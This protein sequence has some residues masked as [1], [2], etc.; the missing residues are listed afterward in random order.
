MK[1]GNTRKSVAA[2][3]SREALVDGR[4]PGTV[5]A[6][7]EAELARRRGGQEAGVAPERLVAVEV[8]GGESGA[9]RVD[10]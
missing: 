9:L 6:E 10:L 1:T 2:L 4:G 7:V 5:R 8:R 3:Q